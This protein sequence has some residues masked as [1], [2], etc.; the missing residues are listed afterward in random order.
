[1]GASEQ[2]K[3]G[4]MRVSEDKMKCGRAQLPAV[5]KERGVSRR[6]V[7]VEVVTKDGGRRADNEPDG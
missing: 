5:W 6:G 4:Y 7:Q 2:A 3:S 1:M